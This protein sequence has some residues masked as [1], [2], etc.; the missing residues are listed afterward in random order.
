M[1]HERASLLLAVV[2]PDHGL[3]FLIVTVVGPSWS[4]VWSGA[5]GFL[6][7]SKYTL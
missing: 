5:P 6:Q 3:R 4:V 7:V 2:G 1:S